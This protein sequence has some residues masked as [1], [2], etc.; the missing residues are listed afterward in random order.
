MRGSFLRQIIILFFLIGILASASSFAVEIPSSTR[1]KKAIAEA[2]QRIFPELENQ[3][4]LLGMPVYIRIFKESSELELWVEK[5][6]IFKLFKT[7][8]ICYYSGDLGPKLREGD[9]QSPEGF[10]FVTPRQLNPYSTFYLSFNIGYP[11]VYDR[12]QGRTGSAIMVHGDCVSIGC[13][14]MTDEQIEEIYTIIDAA[15]RNGQPFFRVHIFPFRMTEENMARHEESK[16][17]SFWQNLKKGYDF[18]SESKRPPNV[19][20]LNG[21]YSFEAI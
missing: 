17:F 18:F 13:Y 7:Y 10:Y 8:P 6:D 2:S 21:N 3:G 11:N 12:S 1:S 16:W 14:A 19:V 4:L 9:N 20:V 15:L 5:N